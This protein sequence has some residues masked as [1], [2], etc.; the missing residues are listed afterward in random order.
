ML[1]VCLE[2]QHVRS[3]LWIPAARVRGREG[4]AEGGGGERNR[5]RNAFKGAF[6]SEEV[7]AQPALNVESQRL[8]A[9]CLLKA[10]ERLLPLGPKLWN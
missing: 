7:F 4:C 2:P 9:S 10:A 8:T 1:P 6:N 5:D 3:L